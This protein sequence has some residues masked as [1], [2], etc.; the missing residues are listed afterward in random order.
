MVYVILLIGLSF[1]FLIYLGVRFYRS[2]YSD[3]GYLTH[4]LP[5]KASSLITVK[6]VTA[7]ALYFAVL[8]ALYVMVGFLFMLCFAQSNGMSIAD[9]MSNLGEFIDETITYLRDEMDFS[10][11]QSVIIVLVSSIITP[12]S[13][14]CILFGSI[15]L[16]QYSWKNKGPMGIVAYV[17][18]RT[19]MGFTCGILNIGFNMLRLRYANKPEDMFGLTNDNTLVNLFVEIFFSLILYFWSIH[20]VKNRLNM[21]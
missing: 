2:M 12:F 1:G 5:V 21:E 15:T 13:A 11:A 18:V 20:I 3:E 16:G 14:M 7:G 9:V 8:L 6:M 10:I 4:T 19:V 17:I